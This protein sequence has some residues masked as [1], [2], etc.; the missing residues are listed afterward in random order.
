MAR[1]AASLVLLLVTWLFVSMP[2]AAQGLTHL[3][4]Q[5]DRLRKAKA[6]E[7]EAIAKNDSLLL[8]EAW[9]LY[10]KTYAFSGDY[11]VSQQYFV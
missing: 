8:A 9:Y 6:T 11:R 5:S 7:Q 1:F 4:V 10:G 2:G 3:T